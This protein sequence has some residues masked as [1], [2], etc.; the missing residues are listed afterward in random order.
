MTYNPSTGTLSATIFNGAL[1]GDV[2]GTVSDISNILNTG[3]ITVSTGTST[4]SKTFSFNPSAILISPSKSY[5]EEDGGAEAQVYYSH[6]VSDN[7]N[8]TYDLT[9]NITYSSGNPA[10]LGENITFTYLVFK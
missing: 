3:I 9:I 8:G 7:G 6:I 1:T 4:N 10:N 2:T 5:F